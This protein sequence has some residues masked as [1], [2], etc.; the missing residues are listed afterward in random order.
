MEKH[1]CKLCLRRFANGRA[2]GGHVRSHMMNL[3]PP[4]KP[5]KLLQEEDS[6]EEEIEESLPSSTSFTSSEEED[7]EEEDEEMFSSH[8]SRENLKKISHLMDHHE[9][10]SGSVVLQDRES[11]SE[12]SRDLFSKIQ[13]KRIRSSRISS[14][15]THNFCK[16][17]IFLQPKFEKKLKNSHLESPSSIEAETL[18][19]ISE[20]TTEEDVAYCLM[21]LSRD[22]WIRTQY[23]D[24][25]EEEEEEESEQAE[26]REKKEQSKHQYQESGVEAKGT[27]SNRSRGKYRCETCDK[28]FRSYQALGGHRASHKRIKLSNFN[29]TEEKG[30]GGNAFGSS[31]LVE[32]QKI[33]ECPVCFKVFSSGQALGGHKR[34]HGASSSLNPS[35]NKQSF[36][37]RSGGEAL[38]DLNLPAPVDDEDDISQV[39]QYSAVSGDEFVHQIKN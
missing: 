32:E 3:F 5:N 2:L 19:S 24:P 36:S 10:N 22:K 27:K 33:H 35:S 7:E 9:L 34:S 6:E 37:S 15:T 29:S 1:K 13:T 28:V 26:E 38:I 14:G 39:E 11:G 17:S 20:T 30:R 18:S 12:S 21:M 31:L 16:D 4:P 8:D 25:S 23:I